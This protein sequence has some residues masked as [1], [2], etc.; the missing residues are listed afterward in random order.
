MQII[1]W[2]DTA[3]GRRMRWAVPMQ[4]REGVGEVDIADEMTQTL[5]NASHNYS[6]D[7]HG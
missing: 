4:E 1:L 2:N 3:M 6:E 5:R 7:E